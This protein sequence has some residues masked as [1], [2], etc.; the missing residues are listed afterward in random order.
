MRQLGTST[1]N[2]REKFVM[3][4]STDGCLDNHGTVVRRSLYDDVTT[5]HFP[6]KIWYFKANEK[7]ELLLQIVLNMWQTIRPV[8]L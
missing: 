3:V 2:F 7:H 1:I 8:K 5:K 4:I 6:S